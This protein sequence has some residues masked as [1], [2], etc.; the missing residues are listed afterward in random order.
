MDVLEDDLPCFRN[1]D[2]C[3][4]LS[5]GPAPRLILTSPDWQ[6]LA[7]RRT[8]E[9][10]F[11]SALAG[12][13][14]LSE[15]PRLRSG[16]L[17]RGVSQLGPTWGTAGDAQRTGLSARQPRRPRQAPGPGS[18]QPCFRIR[19]A[20]AMSSDCGA[21]PTNW[22]TFPKM[23]SSPRKTTFVLRRHRATATG[24]LTQ[25]MARPRFLPDCRF[26]V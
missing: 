18:V 15:E 19:I 26:G 23:A 4:A 10:P 11:R 1:P 22:D 12:P 6:T 21:L 13:T 7:D 8:T 5:A 20:R 2:H 16:A 14:H 24:S 9:P 25:L 3:P 17:L